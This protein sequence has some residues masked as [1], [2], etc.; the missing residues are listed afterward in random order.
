MR[1]QNPP[2]IIEKKDL[3]AFCPNK[4]MAVWSSNPRVFLKFN[5]QNVAKCPYCGT[6]YLIKLDK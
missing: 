5:A 1:K 6:I 2:I 3:P 4:T